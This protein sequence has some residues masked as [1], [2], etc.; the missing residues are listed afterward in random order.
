MF[1]V[2]QR[3]AL[4]SAG[5]AHCR[6][7]WHVEPTERPEMN[8]QIADPNWLLPFDAEPQNAKRVAHVIANIT[9]PGLVHRGVE[10]VDLQTIRGG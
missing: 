5:L 9:A 7:T 4:H 6:A 10:T 3:T 8:W 1:P 2:T